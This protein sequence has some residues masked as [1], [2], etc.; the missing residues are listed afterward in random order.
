MKAAQSQLN[1]ITE[2]LDNQNRLSEINKINMDEINENDCKIKARM[3]EYQTESLNLAEKNKA[4]IQKEMNLREFAF[5][6][7]ARRLHVLQTKMARVSGSLKVHE[8]DI[9]SRHSEIVKDVEQISTLMKDIVNVV[10]VQGRET[11]KLYNQ[12]IE[13]MEELNANL[14]YLT[15]AVGTVKHYS[16]GFVKS[17]KEVGIDVK[18][19]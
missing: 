13:Y 9:H 12:T 11:L 3:E 17:F 14:A 1:M 16:E 18:G 15:N 10:N 7:A 5:F 2:L 8:E 19:F 6:D 4:F